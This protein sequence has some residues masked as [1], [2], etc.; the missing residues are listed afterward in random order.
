[1]AS[2]RSAVASLPAAYVA[3]SAAAYLGT[4][5]ATKVLRGPSPSTALWMFQSWSRRACRQL[6]IDVDI[7]GEPGVGPTLYIANHRS[8][9]DIPI[10]SSLLRATFLSNDDVA[11]WPIV[12][13]AARELGVV[14]VDRGEMQARIRAARQI[15]R[16]VRDTSLIIF[17]EGTTNGG[18]LPSAFHGGLFRLLARLGGA[19]VPVTL[20]Y[21][22]RRAYWIE[23]IGAGEHLRRNVLNGD[24]LRVEVHVGAPIAP[25]PEPDAEAFAARVY[26]AVCGPIDACGELTTPRS[27]A[28]T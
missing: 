9:L 8:Y 14:F 6:G 10:L 22:D 24:R 11:S 5:R 12:G 2:F 15:A 13:A 4:Y 25:G 26:D 19:A 18:R 21:S 16:R 27:R 7:I 23:D 28:T 1:M 17:P 20:R 3:A